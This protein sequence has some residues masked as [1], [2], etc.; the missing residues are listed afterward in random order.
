MG[1]RSTIVAVTVLALLL[2]GIALAVIRLY[3][4]AGPGTAEKQV[5]ASWNVLGAVPSD[6]TA[7]VVFD[8]SSR[9]AGLMADSTGFL[10]GFLAPGNPA[11][12]Q[13]LN[14]LSHR[15]VAV[16]LHNSGS[17]V[18]L[19]AAESELADS[20]L[21]ALA[22]KAGLKL[23]RSNGF[24]LASRSETFLNAGAR[25]LEGGHSILGTRHLQ[26]LVNT[27]SGPK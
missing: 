24:L 21:E 11:F 8:G 2:A 3:K 16:S 7:V 23:M 14:A 18:P 26:D 15:K 20:T 25:Q 1:K 19:V 5:A 12:M 22:A 6:A 27:V 4:P 13:Y 17:L 9:A 10:Q